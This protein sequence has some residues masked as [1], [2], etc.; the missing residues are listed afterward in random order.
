[1]YTE[2]TT[3][4]FRNCPKEPF[5]HA[6]TIVGQTDKQDWIIRNSWGTSWGK[7]GYLIMRGDNT[8]GVC[9][10]TIVPE[11]SDDAINPLAP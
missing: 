4:P 7:N 9:L 2:A 6:I 11:L 3:T 8:C 5:N 1:L 10:N